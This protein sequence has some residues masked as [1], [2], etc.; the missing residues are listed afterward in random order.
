MAQFK[1]RLESALEIRG[2]KPV[3]LARTTGINEGAIS[4]YRKGAYKATQRNLEKISKALNFPIPWLMGI[5]DDDGSGASEQSPHNITPL[6]EMKKIPL[7]GQIACG[8]PILAEENIEDYID[9]PTHIHADYALT[10]KGESMI[11]AGIQD[12]DVVYIRKQAEVENGQ[13]AAVRVDCEDATLKRFN[14]D[15]SAVQLIAENPKFPPQVFAGENINRI[16][17]IGLAVA[18]THVI[19]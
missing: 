11:N 14:Y 9:L 10:C 1:D 19:H 17:V 13:I 3:D 6:P 2:M 8:L 16:K 5:S 7:V 18:Y 4:Q 15:G 12:G